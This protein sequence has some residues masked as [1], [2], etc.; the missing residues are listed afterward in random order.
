MNWKQ[1]G[2]EGATEQ[3][4]PQYEFHGR[5]AHLQGPL[6]GHHPKGMVAWRHHHRIH[7]DSLISLR[8]PP[9][10]K[11]NHVH[12]P[13]WTRPMGSGAPAPPPRQ[14]PSNFTWGQQCQGSS[15]LAEV[16][17]FSRLLLFNPTKLP[18]S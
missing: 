10:M 4:V 5:A 3:T 15:T 12:F 1:D 2:R 13:V 9:D 16:L 8:S 17:T 11:L 7:Q 18:R 14:F 6:K